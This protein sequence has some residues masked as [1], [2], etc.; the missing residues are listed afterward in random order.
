MQLG[1]FSTL[2]SQVNKAKN[3]DPFTGTLIALDP[4]E[5]TGVAVFHVKESGVWLAWEEQAPTWPFKEG[6]TYFRGLLDHPDHDLFPLSVVHEA[7]RVYEWKATHH[8][9]S[10]VPTLQ[11]I[12]CV[13][14]LALMR[15]DPLAVYQQT[16]QVAKNFCTDDFLKQH[17]CYISGKR[18]SR[19]AIR[20]GLYFLLFGP[21]KDS[22]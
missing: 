2:R 17:G 22:T 10:D 4:G 15:D 11:L 1:K 18:H 13:K 3:V 21:S 7:Y 16:A 6:L 14:T 19:D 5:T 9:W 8:S 20:H 12:G